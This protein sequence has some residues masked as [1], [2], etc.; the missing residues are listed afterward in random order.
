MSGGR[1]FRTRRPFR[2]QRSVRFGDVDPAGMVYYP[3]LL[4]WIHVAMEAFFAEIVGVRYADYLG[5]H[6]MGLPTVRLEV[7]FHRP[8]R[9]GDEV[10]IEV[11]VEKVGRTSITWRYR[12]YRS[13]EP[14]PA[15]EARLVTVNLDLKAGEKRALPAWLG[16]RL[17]S[18]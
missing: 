10:A 6:G 5:E 17:R 4:D 1:P 12:L 7:D 2:T 15:A 11:E 13:P 16:E 8:L 18:P 14:G 3:R 9:F